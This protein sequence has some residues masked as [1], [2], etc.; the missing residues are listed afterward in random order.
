MKILLVDPACY[1]FLGLHRHY[2]P[3][4]LTYIAATLKQDGHE[5]LIYDADHD[6]SGVSVSFVEVAE[7]YHLYVEALANIEHPIWKEFDK[8]LDDFKPQ[9]VGFSTLSAKV[10]GTLLMAKMVKNKNPQIKTV[11]GGEHSTIRP[12]DVLVGDVDYVVMGEGEL[13][14]RSLVQCLENGGDTGNIRGLAFLNQNGSL[15]KNELMENIENLDNLP[16]PAIELLYKKETYRPI[17]MGLMMTERGCPYECTFCGL[18]T[19][20]GKKVRCHSI[21]RIIDEI[22]H[23]RDMYKTEYFSFRNGTFTLSRERIN[24]LCAEIEKLD[25]K[26]KWECLTRV[27]HLDKNLLEQMISAGCSAIRIGVESGSERILQYMRKKISLSQIR[28]S[29]EMLNESGIF[30]SAF[31]MFGVPEETEITMTETLKL[32]KEISP[33]FITLSKF[34]PIPGTVMY[35]EIL[36]ASM[37]NEGETD[38]SWALNQA[39]DISFTK[40]MKRQDFFDLMREIAE[41]VKNHNERQ[42]RTRKDAR[43]KD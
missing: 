32:M 7:N 40:R 2:F 24:L 16:F 39:M 25:F 1:R 31:F 13:V 10:G 38:W 23:R 15:V 41:F 17:D 12:I 4:G 8:I 36:K 14:L 5:I 35:D 6:S 9:I 3:L 28:A 20:W 30:W 18:S 42:G 33:P 11:S 21:K 43:S 26:I 34:T 22:V 27:G 37:I 29:A 19:I